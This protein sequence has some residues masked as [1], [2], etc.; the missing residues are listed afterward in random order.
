VVAQIQSK[1]SGKCGKVL[2]RAHPVLGRGEQPVDNH[3]G[4]ALTA[5]LSGVKIHRFLRLV[6]VGCF[7]FPVEDSGNM[8]KIYA[9]VRGES[10]FKGVRDLVDNVR[11]LRI[12]LICRRRK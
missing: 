4:K 12:S 11:N 3:H 8:G 5:E 2:G 6:P 7:R 1:G 10:K 9:Y